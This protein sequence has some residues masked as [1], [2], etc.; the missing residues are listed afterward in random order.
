MSCAIIVAITV[1]I[2]AGSIGANGN[3][4][5]AI[6]VGAISIYLCIK[7]NKALFMYKRTDMSNWLDTVS[8]SQFKHAWD[9]T[10]IA[11]D[12]VNSQIHLASVFNG[13]IATK[14]Y[15]LS[16]VK[17]WKWEIPGYTI[18]HPG[19]V[20]GGGL[21]GAA[22]NIGTGIGAVIGASIA[23]SKVQEATGMTIRVA[24]IDYPMWFVK[25]SMWKKKPLQ[26]EQEMTRWMEILDQNVN[27]K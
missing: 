5:L 1:T 6:I 25:F 8:Q 14:V 21:H 12:T 2:Y 24:D 3:I 11:V 17:E 22:S 4:I 16:S 18:Y 15:P 27:E 7:F 19:T 26:L 10:G 13:Q 20:V 9:G 23:Q